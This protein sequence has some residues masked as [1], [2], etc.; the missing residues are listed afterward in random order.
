V[1]QPRGTAKRLLFGKSWSYWPCRCNQR[2]CQQRKTLKKH[3]EE[4]MVWPTCGCGGKLYVD[5]YRAT[6]AFQEADRGSPTCR[7]NGYHY[8]HSITGVWCQNNPVEPTEQQYKERY[9]D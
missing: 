9:G 7:C 4:Y 8:P 1:K 3:P 2:D 5:Y 6:K